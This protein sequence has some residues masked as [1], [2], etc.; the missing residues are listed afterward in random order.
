M[1]VRSC[2]AF[3]LVHGP[4]PGRKPWSG[5]TVAPFGQTLH[6]RIIDVMDAC[7]D[8]RVRHFAFAQRNT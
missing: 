2:T 3:F 5:N 1:A 6:R 4:F 7:R 8:A